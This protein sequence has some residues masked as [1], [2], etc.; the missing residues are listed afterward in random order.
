M[1]DPSSG[2]RKRFF[3]AFSPP[4]RIASGT[5]LALPSPTP[6]WPAPSPTTTNAAKENRR[7]P[8]TTLATRLML[9]TRSVRSRSFGLIGVVVAIAIPCLE[10]QPSLASGIRHRG[11]APL[12]GEPVAVEH[13]LL[14]LHRLALL[15]DQLSHPL[16]VSLLVA[17]GGLPLELLGERGGRRQ[18]PPAGVV[19]HLRVDV[20][21]ALVHG[22]PRAL[23]SS[24]QLPADALLALQPGFGLRH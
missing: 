13:H 5:S 14:H 6:T 8:F 23:G 10:L 21:E 4:L 15:G 9:T 17:V 12:V 19:H 22:E 1:V 7:P 2:T 16:G 20:L 3:L 24:R 11:D 18:R